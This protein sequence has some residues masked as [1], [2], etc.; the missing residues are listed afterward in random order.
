MDIDN[1]LEEECNVTQVDDTNGRIFGADCAQTETGIN[2]YR[3]HQVVALS[4]PVLGF[5]YC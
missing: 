4:V 3:Y 2:L 1:W 5:A